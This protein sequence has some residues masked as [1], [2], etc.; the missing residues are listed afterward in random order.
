[1]KRSFYYYFGIV[2]V[3]L[4]AL[5]PACKKAESLEQRV[6]RK[7]DAY[8]SSHA[9]R[10][11][12]W[13]DSGSRLTE[14][15]RFLIFRRINETLDTMVKYKDLNDWTRRIFPYSQEAAWSVTTNLDTLRDRLETLI[16]KSGKGF[17]ILFEAADYGTWVESQ[18]K[19]TL[20]FR[21]EVSTVCIPC[22]KIPPVLLAAMM[23]HECGH[24]LQVILD[25]K[26]YEGGPSVEVPMHTLSIAILETGVPGFKAKIDE[27][28]SRGTY[29]DFREAIASIEEID[30]YDIDRLVLSGYDSSYGSSSPEVVFA[31]SLAV[32][33]EYTRRHG[34]DE[35]QKEKVYDWLES[36][37]HNRAPSR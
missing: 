27:I 31:A 21:P 24:A 4:A 33:L 32:G 3:V 25:G 5:I 30:W 37:C 22:R 6:K 17:T 12:W 13:L 36:V 18:S 14:D 26:S 10:G 1:M 11:A 29:A 8:T 2:F 7:T 34:D 16:I 15:Q 20:R 28:V 9:L 19:D 35:K 23:Y